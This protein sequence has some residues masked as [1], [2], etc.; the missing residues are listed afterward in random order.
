MT[1]HLT[2]VHK[3][4]HI[5]Y[6]LFPENLRLWTWVISYAGKY[7]ILTQQKYIH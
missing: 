5:L 3:V 6:R 7:G 1:G 4:K 2:T